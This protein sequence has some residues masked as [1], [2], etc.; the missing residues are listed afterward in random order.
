[1]N[2]RS[3][4]GFTLIELIIFIVVVGAGL[5]GILSVSTTSI[6][7][8]ADPLVRKQALAIA[9]SLLEEIVQ[10]Q[11]ANPTGGYSGA[12][13]ALFDDVDDY[14]NYTS[15]TIVDGAGNA[16]AG[17]GSYSIAPAVSVTAT[18][19]NGVA[20]KKV[21]VSVTGP[22]GVVSVTGYRANY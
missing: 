20:A 17:L 6:K 16:I 7:S 18:T 11:Y 19:L 22:Q 14:N 12:S 13:R 1:M 3:Q 5:A 15:A 21:V 10:Q 2:S 8:S 9:E 4:K